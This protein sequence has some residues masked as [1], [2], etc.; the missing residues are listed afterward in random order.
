[1]IRK[2]YRAPPQ[3]ALVLAGFAVVLLMSVGSV[4]LIRQSQATNERL[5]HALTVT[6]LIATMR[7]DLR[8][9][10]S[11]QRG[12]LLTGKAAYL[13]DYN[14]TRGR[15]LPEIDQL[16]SLAGDEAEAKQRAGTL[17]ALL[18][19]KL[20]ELSRT[21]DLELSDRHREALEVV[22]TDAGLV[23]TQQ[24]VQNLAQIAAEEGA[25]IDAARRSADRTDFALFAI[26]LAG[27]V[28]IGLLAYGSFLLFRRSARQ[29]LASERAVREMNA[30]LEARVA[31]RTADLEEANAEIQ[32]YAYVVT[33][34]LRSPLVN[35]MGFTS[36]L[37]TLRDDL[38]KRSGESEAQVPAADREDTA[39]AGLRGD[40]DEAIHFIKTSIAKMDGLINAILKLSRAG[41]RE[42]AIQPI[43]LNDLVEVIAA[44]FRH[45]IK[46]SGAE[47]TIGE[48]PTVRS[49]RMALEQIISNLI[50]NAIKYLRPG[51]A[52]RISI[53]AAETPLAYRISVADNGR[54]IDPKDRERVFELFRRAGAQDRPGEGIGLAHAR[55]LARRIGGA[56]GVADN[57]GGG[58]VFTLSLSK[59]WMA[60][61]VTAAKGEAA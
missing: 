44:D 42:L 43:D 8:R 29:I 18:E 27:V 52:G 11:G 39:L 7:A 50:D 28:V 46:E 22:A 34:D 16:A 36:E 60:R 59:H 25:I 38:F 10:E 49:D 61:Q 12:F 41:R 17:R 56:L 51:V 33:H 37:E 21:V 57:P 53:S 1:M 47:L 5:A 3:L 48:L 30:E 20:A 31:E 19:A 6:N 14:A 4:W 58:T 54:G 26:N 2:G 23:L 55:G 9:T 35:I 32:R 45:R 13:N 24:I 40:F 15:L